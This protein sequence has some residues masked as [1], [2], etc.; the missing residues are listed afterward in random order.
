M[1]D[2]SNTDNDLDDAGEGDDDGEEGD[3]I[4]TT[5]KAAEPDVTH[6]SVAPR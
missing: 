3:D 2:A 5:F 1:T 4:G 6:P